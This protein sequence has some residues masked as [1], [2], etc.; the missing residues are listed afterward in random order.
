MDYG[1]KVGEVFKAYLE[2]IKPVKRKVKSEGKEGVASLSDK[3]ELSSKAFE[4]KVAM[5]SLSSAPEIRREKVEEIKRLLE[6]GKYS[7]DLKQVAR[8]LLEDIYFP[9]GE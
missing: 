8:K 7:P 5:E 1:K 3:V 9:S 2:G 6:E 4:V